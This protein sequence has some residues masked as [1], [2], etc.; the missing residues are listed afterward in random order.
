MN[1]ADRDLQQRVLDELAWEPS[2]EAAHI[3]VAVRDGVV[4]LS[5]HVSS[6]SE[7]L[8][9]EQAVGRVRGVRAVAQEIQVRLPY[10]R[11]TGDDEIAGRAV[12]ILGWDAVVPRD[13]VRVKVEDGLVTLTGEV[14]W[15]FQR[16]AAERA[17]QKLGGVVG[18]VNLIRVQAKAQPADIRQRIEEALRRDAELEAGRLTVSVADGRVV[19]G[20]HVRSP[21]ERQAAERAAWAAPGV[22]EVEDRISIG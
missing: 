9:A 2:V 16:T 11:K 6:Y 10:E 19:L 20:G 21:R 12:Q 17:V 22:R 8:A 5:G 7:K 15:Q 18:V 13:A 1:S 3:G 14:E 4:T